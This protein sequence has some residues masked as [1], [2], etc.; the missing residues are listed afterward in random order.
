MMPPPKADAAPLFSGMQLPANVEAERALLGAVMR[1]NKGYHRVSHLIATAHFF[2]PIHQRVWDVAS[3]LIESGQGVDPIV[4]KS[5]FD[6]ARILNEVGGVAYLLELASAPAS[7]NMAPE[8]AR[9]VRECWVRR[10]LIDA[11]V[12]LATDAYGVDGGQVDA[13]KLA[14]AAMVEIEKAIGTAGEDTFTSLDDAMDAAMAAMD[15]HTAGIST[16]FRCL[17]LRLGGLEP[18]HVYV[19]AGR[20]GMGKSA[21][22]HQI[23][24][25]VARGGAGVLELSLEMSATQ[26]GRRT[27]VTA[28][29]VPVSAMKNGV[30]QD[31]AQRIVRARQELAGLPLTIDDAG[32]QTPRMI[33]A[34]ARQVKRKHGL[35]LVMVDHL[36]LTRPDAGDEK[37]GPTHAIEK[38][39]GMMLQIAKDCGVPVLLLA[40]LN[41]GVEGRDDH[42]PN[43]G[44]LR[45]SGAI[46]Q[47]AYAIGFV[48]REEY[49]LRNAPEQN[50]G[51][52]ADK[53][54]SRFGMFR[55]AQDR[56]AG[57]A[58]VIWGKVRDGE[59]GTD[60][61]LFDG[62]TVSFGEDVLL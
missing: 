45:Q 62:K 4:L 20:P 52:S 2:D 33:A 19:I 5:E 40:Q 48:Y 3:R 26:L 61:L 21:L 29:G 35:D 49:Y 32:G 9:A 57:K 44:D 16:G 43:L 23:A 56:A 12:N 17:D 60:K 13:A 42:R 54:A 47:D 46:E 38:A 1:N 37:H 31:Q 18:G 25:N 22:G 7:P 27:L 51:E 39:S 6:Q 36:N 30:S 15:G 53:Y 28:S 58:E 41:R 50:S 10:E 11:A 8:Y 24:I 34:K 59:P 14:S 55:Q